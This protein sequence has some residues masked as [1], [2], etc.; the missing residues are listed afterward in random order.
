M[1]ETAPSQKTFNRLSESK[2]PYLLQHADNPVAWY[3][4]GENAFQ[5]AKEED[6][7]IFLSIGYATCHWCHVMA[8]ESFEDTEVA[9][10]L[11]KHFISIKVDREERPDVDQV[12]MSVCQALTGRGGWPLS[13]FMTP[14]KRPFF[15]GTYFPRHS[16]MGMPGFI[17]LCANV[18]IAWKNKRKDLMESSEKITASIQQMDQMDTKQHS[19]QT[20]NKSV[21]KDTLKECFEYFQNSFDPEWGGFGSAPK[22]PSPHNYSFLLRWHKRTGDKNALKMVE[23]SLQSMR[24]GGIF[25][26]I[27]SGFHRYSV[28]ERWLV[29]HF[30]KMLYD[31]AMLSLAYTDAYQV[32]GK[33]FYGQVVREI[34]T[35]V[36]RDMTSPEG[37]FYCAE[38]ADSPQDANSRGEE[39]LFYVWNP[40]EIIA[41][42]GADDGDIF[43]RFYNITEKGNFEHNLS[44]PHM[45]QSIEAFA[46]Q[47]KVTSKDLHHLLATCRGKLFSIREKRIHPLKDDKILAGW[48]GLMIAALARASQALGE[49]EYLDAA[50][51][52]ADFVLASMGRESGRLY[53]RHRLGESAIPGFLEDYTFMVWGL[54][55]LY[56]S[57]NEVRYLREAIN[58]NQTMHELF[59]DDA[60]GGFFFTG[61]DSEQ[62]I[63]RSK[64]I[65]DGATPSGNSVALM[66]L[67]RLAR[68][69]GDT[70]LEQQ[71]DQVMTTFSAQIMSHPM[72]FTQ[73]LAACD[74]I[75][76]PSQE[77]VVVGDPQDRMVKEMLAILKKTY[78]PNKVLLFRGKGDSYKALDEMAP[79]LKEIMTAGSERPTTFWCQQFACQEPITSIEGLNSV[80]ASTRN[81]DSQE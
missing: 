43:C 34:V 11:N 24:Q 14:D 41:H 20:M 27:G 50:K 56:E 29:P 75:I 69:T 3:P 32:T 4:W 80:I 12:Y 23:K 6:K 81:P 37:G 59:W 63:S 47:E 46:E 68:M 13:I 74:F 7:P 42:L 45:T 73:F 39:G 61:K 5:R 49:P 65:Y 28:D 48:N 38:D 1:N 72:A 79:F 16:R 31:Q 26:H 8:H 51:K 2:S 64:E 40:Q 52:S 25:D 44:I 19:D 60:N 66:N 22:F 17:D 15:A 21:N 10:Y 9:D 77:I 57:G 62:M 67:M 30:E 78:L 53:R 18:I 58:L 33:E 54:I 35:Y 55:E 76:G 71:A 36:L 70:A